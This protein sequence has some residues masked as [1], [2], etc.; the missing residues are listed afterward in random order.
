MRFMLTYTLKPE[1]RD[2]AIARFLQTQGAP[3]E[4]VQM[5]G[6]WQ[7]VGSLGGF[8]LC[9]SNDAAKIADWV[10][11][12]SDLLT[13]QV[14]PVLDDQEFGAMLARMKK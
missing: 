12:W 5:L 11:A 7:T 9:E 8:T 14:A 4:G 13:F 10:F 3:P 2:A 1:A 6:R